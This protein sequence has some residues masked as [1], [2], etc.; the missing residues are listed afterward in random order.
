MQTLSRKEIALPLVASSILIT[1]TSASVFIYEHANSPMPSLSG[2]TRL[3]LG[4]I[5]FAFTGI[6]LLAHMVVIFHEWKRERHSQRRARN[7]IEQTLNHH[8]EKHPNSLAAKKAAKALKKGNPI[9]FF[10]NLDEHKELLVDSAREK[11]YEKSRIFR[12]IAQHSSKRDTEKAIFAFTKS[13]EHIPIGANRDDIDSLI[14]LGKLYLRKGNIEAAHENFVRAAT[15]AKEQIYH[16]ENIRATTGIGLVSSYKGNFKSAK[17]IFSSCLEVAIEEG[18]REDEADLYRNLTWVFYFLSDFRGASQLCDRAIDYDQSPFRKAKLAQDLNL[19][20]I[21]LFAMGNDRLAKSR[22]IDALKLATEAEDLE[23]Q[24]ELYS[25]LGSMYSIENNLVESQAYHKKS[26][27]LFTTLGN[28]RGIANQLGCF[29]HIL[30]R[31]KEFDE[32]RKSL[33][34]SLE[35]FR[36]I[37]YRSG[38]ANT[39]RRMALFLELTGDLKGA[40][41]H[42]HESLE[43]DTHMERKEGQAIAYY[44]IAKILGKNSEIEGARNSALRADVLFEEIGSRYTKKAKKLRQILDSETDREITFE[45]IPTH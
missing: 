33:K 39:L 4:S 44:K 22:F 14:K 21:L 31:E 17:K 9:A 16:R 23:Q 2:Y 28:P 32:A 34:D 25:N 10:S 19:L 5:F 26:Y 11:L 38:E 43:L 13:V 12:E 1:I 8:I 30:L 36:E 6:S 7:E 45:P 37:S 35:L 18:W 29:G 24:A 41:H 40:L 20:G 3:A 15:E 42:Y 27:D